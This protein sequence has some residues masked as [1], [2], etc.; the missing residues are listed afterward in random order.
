MLDTEI[1]DCVI[2]IL[3]KADLHPVTMGTY[4]QTFGP[5]FETK[6][7]IRIY[8]EFFEY[9]GM[10]GAN[11]ATL[12]QEQGM[13]CVTVFYGEEVSDAEAEETQKL[14]AELLGEDVDLALVPGGQPVYAYLIAVE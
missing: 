8:K 11:E 2:A 14:L 4:L 5:R 6:A 12:A 3:E 10:T 7:E 9:V 13:A 1:R